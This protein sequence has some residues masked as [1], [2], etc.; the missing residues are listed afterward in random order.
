[1]VKIVENEGTVSQLSDDELFKQ[2]KEFGVDVG[3]ILGSTRTVYERKLER[4]LQGDSGNQSSSPYSGSDNDEDDD[5]QE[6]YQNAHLPIITQPPRTLPS[7][8]YG[9]S[10]TDDLI[11]RPRESLNQS[12]YNRLHRTGGFGD[13]PSHV[14][15]EPPKAAAKPKYQDGPLI[16]T[17]S[18]IKLVL[19]AI[20]VILMTLVYQNME[21]KNESPIPNLN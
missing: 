19:I 11:V 5:A 17:A 14:L 10:S 16:S 9:H 7:E 6:I 20:M 2:L 8:N 1:M 13:S 18:V 3:P 21:E 12:T 4:L 15:P